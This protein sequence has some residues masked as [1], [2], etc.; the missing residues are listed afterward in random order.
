MFS[1]A[2]YPQPHE[3]IA[4]SQKQKTTTLIDIF[5]DSVKKYGDRP[6]LGTCDDG[7]NYT[8]KTYKEVNEEVYQ[9]ASA[10][11]ECGLNAGDRVVNFSVN[12]PQWPVIDFGSVFI[13]AIHVPM[14]PTLSCE[15]MTY[16]VDDCEARVIVASSKEQITKVIDSFK[17]GNLQS[18]EHFVV[19]ENFDFSAVEDLP[20]KVQTWQWQDFLHLGQEKLERN[21]DN[22]EERSLSIRTDDI[23]SLVYTS[24]T[25]GKPKGAMLMHGNFASQAVTLSEIVAVSC[26]DVEMCFLPL[27]HVFERVIYYT[28]TYVGAC[29]GYARSIKYLTADLRILRPTFVPSVPRLFE[30]MFAKIIS[31]SSSGLKKKVFERAI[32]IGRTYREAKR[33]GKVSFWLKTQYFMYEKLVFAKIKQAVGGRI[34]HFISGGAP[35]RVDVINFFLDSGLSILEGYGLTETSPVLCL[36]RPDKVYPGTVGEAIAGVT[37]KIAPDGELCVKGPNVM[38]GYFKR[39]EDTAAVFDEEGYFHTGDICEFDEKTN[40]YSITDRKKEILV[41]SNG[42]NVAPALLENAIKSS[43]WIEQVVIVGNNRSFV[44]AV[45]VPNFSKVEDWA[46]GNGIDPADREALISNVKLEHFLLDEIHKVCVDFSSYEQVRRLVILP[47]ELSAAEGEITPTL[48]VKRRIVNAH[49][50]DL[51]E[52]MYTRPNKTN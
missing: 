49:F 39:P 44:G 28:V 15:E 22:I 17:S 13:G 12:S 21:R 38:R 20:E 2:E 6:D 30:K 18:I 14:Y 25:T 5:N 50:E 45:V 16:I 33:D 10:L 1:L 40:C 4:W 47:R 48:K 51:I 37:L 43:E 29:V 41:L 42:K 9:F 7:K 3:L 35:S 19:I 11:L 32:Q 52:S 24:G 8:F 27:S 34:R 46:K 23:C 36:N 26:E 31:N